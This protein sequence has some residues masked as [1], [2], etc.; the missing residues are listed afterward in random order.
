MEAT[1][2]RVLAA[3]EERARLQEEL[4]KAYGCTVLSFTMNDSDSV[5]VICEKDCT[6]LY[7]QR[8]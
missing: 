4:R 6:V 7:I 5:G 1:L 8:K 2:Q 3:R